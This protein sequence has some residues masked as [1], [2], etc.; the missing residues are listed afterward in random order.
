[1]PRMTIESGVPIPPGA[2]E[3]ALYYDPVDGFVVEWTG[4]KYIRPAEADEP[5]VV[6]RASSTSDSKAAE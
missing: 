4:H 3:G 1:M 2:K 6:P 5:I